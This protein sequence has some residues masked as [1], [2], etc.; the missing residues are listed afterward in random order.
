MT[1]YLTG[2]PSRGSMA[3]QEMWEQMHTSRARSG[4]HIPITHFTHRDGPGT[5]VR[6]EDGCMQP[7]RSQGNQLPGRWTGA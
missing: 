4:A 2:D 6:S 5:L 1:M 7:G 3:L